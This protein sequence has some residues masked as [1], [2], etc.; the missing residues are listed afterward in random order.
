MISVNGY[1][2]DVYVLLT[3]DMAEAPTD[4]PADGGNL[5]PATADGLAF[6]SSSKSAARAAAPFVGRPP[7]RRSILIL[8]LILIWARPLAVAVVVAAVIVIADATVRVAIS[9][10][11]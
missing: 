8:I 4:A 11:L 5:C 6:G 2:P 7:D 3:K 10:R 1:A 9:T